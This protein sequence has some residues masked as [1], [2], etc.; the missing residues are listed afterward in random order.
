MFSFLIFLSLFLAS[1]VT[2]FRLTPWVRRLAERFNAIDLPSQRK[3]HDRATPRLGGVAIFLAFAL[4][5]LILYP[6]FPLMG[7]N[8]GRTIWVLIGGTLMLLLG[9]V[10]DLRG[11][12]ARQKFPAQVAIAVLVGLGGYQISSISL[13]WGGEIDLGLFGPVLSVLWIVGL[14][15]AINLIDGLDGLAAG[16]AAIGAFTI[17]VVSLLSGNLAAVVLSLLLAGSTLGFL[18][19][20]FY[21]AKIFMGDSGSLFLGF[22]LA[23][24]S[25]SSS[26]K[27]TLAVPL[28]IPIVALALPIADTLFSIVRRLAHKSPIFSADQGHFHHRLILKGFSHRQAVLLLWGVSAFLGGASI[29]MSVSGLRTVFYLLP[30]FGIAFLGGLRFFDYKELKRTANLLR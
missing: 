17:F 9:I 8:A 22:S 29:L 10:D 19:H 23:V 2:S 11:L 27:S 15:N 20:N 21:P 4:L 3:I 26:Q 28:L 25:L 5:V 16:I 14:S 7:A 18:C 24:L 6:F 1:L 12:N 13:P 30:I